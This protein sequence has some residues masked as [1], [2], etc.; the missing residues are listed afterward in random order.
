MAGERRDFGVGLAIG[1]VGGNQTGI[2]QF[3]GQRINVAVVS[4]Q[5]AQLEVLRA[6]DETPLTVCFKPS[7]DEQQTG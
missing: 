6:P 2:Q 5:V 1:P 7:G 4:G 3:L